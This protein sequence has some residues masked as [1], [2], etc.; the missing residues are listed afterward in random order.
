MFGWVMVCIG[1]V[2][3]VMCV[4]GFRIVKGNFY[5]MLLIRRFIVVFML[6]DVVCLVGLVCID[7]IDDEIVYFVL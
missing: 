1:V 6:D 4:C 5:F 3:V 2:F 7:F